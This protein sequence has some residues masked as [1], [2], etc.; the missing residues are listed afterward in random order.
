[1]DEAATAM[2][3]MIDEASRPALPRYARLH[4]DKARDRWVLL[5]PERVMVPDDT[6][7]EI[8]HMCDG[9]RSLAD[10]VDI[11]AEKYAADRE[12]ISTDVTALLQDLAYRGFLVDAREED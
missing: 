10:I 2:N 8:L 5:V 4:F 6:A 7:V 1:M 12:A 11:L 9:E 3:P